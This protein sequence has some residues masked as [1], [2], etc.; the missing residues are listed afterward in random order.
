MDLEI[1]KRYSYSFFIESEPNVVIN[2]AVI[3]AY[4]YFGDL[5]RIKTFVAHLTFH[6]ESIRKS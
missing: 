6:W 1:V 4:G 5:P 2:K 3:K